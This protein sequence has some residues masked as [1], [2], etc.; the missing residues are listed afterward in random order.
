MCARV[1]HQLGL[2]LRRQLPRKVLDHLPV[3]AIDRGELGGDV[4]VE[5]SSPL[6]GCPQEVPIGAEVAADE[7]GHVQD[8]LGALHAQ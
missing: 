6:V 5:V 8:L 1:D 3:A 2:H 7:G 4:S